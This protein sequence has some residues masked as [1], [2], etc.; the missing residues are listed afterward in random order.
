M[1]LVTDYEEKTKTV[2]PEAITERFSSAFCQ[3]SSRMKDSGFAKVADAITGCSPAGTLEQEIKI[4]AHNNIAGAQSS[5]YRLLQTLDLYKQ[6]SN[7]SFEKH[8]RQHLS[9]AKTAQVSDLR[10]KE[11][12]DVSKKVLMSSTPTDYA[13]KLKSTGYNLTTAEYKAVMQSL[14]GEN[15]TSLSMF[16]ERTLS[17]LKAYKEQFMNGVANWRNGITVQL[18]RCTVTGENNALK[19]SSELI[20]DPLEEMVKKFAKKAYNTK[21]WVHIFGGVMLAITAATIIGGL[22]I[23]RKSAT[24]KQVEAENKLNG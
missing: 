20:G 8:L 12:I 7:G 10:I 16:G 6:I 4:H 23:G 18:G 14:F 2:T 5:F 9:E 11:L 21:T 15:S 24:E 17:G 22:F 19:S 1:K 3:A 13:E